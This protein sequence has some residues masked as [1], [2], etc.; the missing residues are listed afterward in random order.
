MMGGG[1]RNK[2]ICWDPSINRLLGGNALSYL[3][4]KFVDGGVIVFHGCNVGDG[5]RGTA[6]LTA[7]AKVLQVRAVAGTGTQGRNFRNTLKLENT[8]KIAS[9]G[10]SIRLERLAVLYSK[11]NGF[12]SR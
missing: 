1:G 3:K 9:P 6:M 2:R 8:A 11:D 4:G 10:G 7:A 5:H 12:S